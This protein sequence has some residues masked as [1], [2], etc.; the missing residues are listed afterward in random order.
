[1]RIQS[2]PPPPAR[3]SIATLLGTEGGV[4]RLRD[5][6]ERAR[7]DDGAIRVRRGVPNRVR[8]NDGIA[9]LQELILGALSHLGPQ[10][11]DW[12]EGSPRPLH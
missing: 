3:V 12:T 8:R 1:M 9:H 10:G 2:R 5:G 6:A 4:G 7:L 11:W